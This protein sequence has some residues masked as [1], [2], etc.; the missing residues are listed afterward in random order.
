[1]TAPL[2]TARLLAYTIPKARD[3]YDPRDAILYALGTGA[4]L[5]DEVD[6]TSFLYERQI[7][8]LPTMGVVLGSPGFWGMD[9]ATGIDWANVMHGEER[10]CLFQPLDPS[11]TL[12]GET[13]VTDLADKGVGKPALI[14]SV[15]EL[16]TPGG[17]LVAEATETWIVIG[18]GGFGGPRDLPGKSLPGVPDHAPDFQIDL[19]TSVNQAA[20]YRLSGDRNPLHID[21]EIARNAG[22]E[23]P[24]LHG[25]STMGLVA[26]ALIHACCEGQAHRL[27]E[28]ALRFIAP[29]Y[30]G[31]TIRTFIWQDGETLHFR[32]DAAERNVRVIENG[33]GLMA[34]QS[35]F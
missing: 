27:R 21:P 5:S 8:V 32:A 35:S 15:K 19:P 1:M 14:R 28:I 6:E 22:W 30:P 4:G 18:A 23:R 11:G 25:L 33:L 24:I 20:I 34:D 26:R 3:D 2:D 31:D 7:Q 12:I 16:R 17:T 13:K 9:P 29:V 10:L